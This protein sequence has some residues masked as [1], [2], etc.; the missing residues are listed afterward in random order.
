MACDTCQPEYGFFINPPALPGVPIG[1]YVVPM[2]R[3]NGKVDE[4]KPGEVLPLGVL[5]LAALT[6]FVNNLIDE[7]ANPA[8]DPD[9]SPNP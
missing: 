2:V 5:D 3:V 4:L 7:A 1:R 6:V 8:P 9:P